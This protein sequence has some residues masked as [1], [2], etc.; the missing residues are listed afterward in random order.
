MNP[1]TPKAT[2]ILGDGV[3]VDSRNFRERLQGSKPNGLWRSL[4]HWKALETLMSKMSSRC[5]FGHLKHKL[6]PKEGPGVK[7]PV[8]LPTTK[9][10]ESTRFTWLQ[11]ACHIPLESSQQSY[12][13]ALDRIAIQGLLAKLWGSKVARVPFGAISGLPLGSPERKKPF[14]CG[15]RGQPQS[16]L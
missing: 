4:Y 14:G 6:W 2:P 1:H 3:P 13:F 8:W 16:I 10:R 7:L 12:N 15:L 11:G 5:S 9:S